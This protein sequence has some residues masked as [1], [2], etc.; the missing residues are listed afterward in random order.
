[1]KITNSSV[2]RIPYTLK[3]Q[4][5]YWDDTVKGFGIRVGK[6]SKTYIAQRDICRKTCIFSIGKHTVY[7]ADDARKAAK[8]ALV[9]MGKGINLN[10][11]KRAAAV[12][13]TTLREA[14]DMY[15]SSSEERAAVT[16][17]GYQDHLKRYLHVWIDKELK[18]ITR[19]MT[20]ELHQKIAKQHGKYVANG[21]MRTFRAIWN[22]TMREDET[23]PCCPTINVDWFKEYRKQSPIP[24]EE[25]SA[26]Y[27]E[28]MQQKNPVR[29]DVNLVM[30]FTGLRRTD[31][32]TVRFEDINFVKKTLHRPKPKGGSKRAFT[33]PVTDFVMD[34]FKQR[35]EENKIFFPGSA[36]VFPAWS[37]SGHIMEP[38]E[39]AMKWSAHRLRDSYT[40]V[41]NC[42]GLPVYDI[43]VLTNHRPANS[44]VTAG[45]VR[46]SIEQLR[47]SQQKITDYLLSCIFPVPNDDNKV[48]PLHDNRTQ[49]AV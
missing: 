33:I 1:M 39:G 45:Y 6:T 43:E 40:T 7:N 5:T 32:A 11:K 42:A 28:I 15:F 21:A 48:V 16:I 47:I 38:K 9:E 23:L 36:W 24:P 49:I 46:Q 41:A 4:K 37:A 27:Q 3:G 30:L 26:W 34:I 17:Q 8:E 14:A 35:K 12:S 20:R 18:D 44:S 19:K 25:L 13:G 31:A 2:E 22:R 10:D 29:R